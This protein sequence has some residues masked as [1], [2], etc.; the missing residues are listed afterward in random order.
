MVDKL[1]T[2]ESI[3][4]SERIDRSTGATSGLLPA[5]LDVQRVWKWLQEKISMIDR[6]KPSEAAVT[7]A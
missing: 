1:A 3:L 4:A 7:G 6:K 5:A 2:L